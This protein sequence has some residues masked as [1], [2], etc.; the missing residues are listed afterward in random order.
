MRSSGRLEEIQVPQQM[1]SL[2]CRPH[3]AVPLYNLP[4]P[5]KKLPMPGQHPPGSSS[6]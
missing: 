5:G 4:Q 3:A 1:L 6:M 2:A